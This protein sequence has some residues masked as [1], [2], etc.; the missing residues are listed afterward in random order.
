MKKSLYYIILYFILISILLIMCVAGCSQNK[1]SQ[2]EINTPIL[3]KI[4]IY[5]G[6]TLISV[7]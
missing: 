2:S 3:D 5:S 7:S 6:D 1:E 4:Y